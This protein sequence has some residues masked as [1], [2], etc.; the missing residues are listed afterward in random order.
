LFD[1]FQIFGLNIDFLKPDRFYC[2]I[3]A[4]LTRRRY[5]FEKIGE[6]YA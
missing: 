5:I 2:E 6:K 1:E 4:S 3:S